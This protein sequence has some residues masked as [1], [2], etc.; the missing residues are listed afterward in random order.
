MKK[1]F[2]ILLA[3]S[4]LSASLLTGCGGA[5][6]SADGADSTGK[7][8]VT[9]DIFQHKSE[10]AQQLQAAVDV[11]TA[12]NPHVTIN[13]ETVQG[14]DYNTS[15]KAKM[16]GAD[17][18][19]IFGAGYNDLVNNYTDYAEDLS[20]QPWVPHVQKGIL[21]GITVNDK[22]LGLPIS[23]EGY[24]LVYNTEI[25]K[26]AGIDASTLTSYEAIDAAFAQLQSKI[27]AGELA[28]QF[29]LLE[30]VCEYAAK[31]SWVPGIH[32]VN[33]LYAGEFAS[34]REVVDAPTVSFSKTAEFQQTLDLLT[35]YTSA[36]KAG[37]L[38]LLN[39][40]D[41]SSQIGGGLG[42]ERVAVVQQ[43]NWIG[44][45]LKNISEELAAKMDILPLPMKGVAEDRICVDVA[46][47][48]CV[49]SKSNDQER[50]AAKDFLN[51]LFQ[52]D[53]GKK[54][55]VNELGFLPAFDNYQ[56]IEIADP[57]SKAVQRYLA[58]GKTI[59]WMFSAFPSGYESLAAADIQAYLGGSVSWE[60]CIK[61]LESDFA[62]LK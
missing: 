21:S 53:E 8:K 60:E 24:G 27:D 18:V 17:P 28:E 31:E 16:L 29:P 49:N 50:Q 5:G 34:Q 26:A 4:T 15:L 48:W 6:G 55:V 13:L 47:N 43:G 51:W 33:L 45:E 52:S 37:N 19:E 39:A 42:I 46:F 44:P 58:A 40:V 61:K 2:A 11:Y 10:I 7:E 1:T 56:D 62:S 59:P 9:I 36:A 32:T 12:Q 41:Y 38:A 22:V 54:I 23:I 35:K 14:S 57:L 3:I 25:F 20:D 30:A